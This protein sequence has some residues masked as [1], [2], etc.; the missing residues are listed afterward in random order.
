GGGNGGGNSVPNTTLPT[1]TVSS[2]S[3]QSDNKKEIVAMAEKELGA[4]I[5][6]S[7]YDKIV[8]VNESLTAS[9]SN[10]SNARNTT[11]KSAKATGL[12]ETEKK[13]NLIQIYANW[14]NADKEILNTITEKLEDETIFKTAITQGLTIFVGK[15]IANEI[16]K[17]D[18]IIDSII[19][20][21]EDIK[22]AIT[23]NKDKFTAVKYDLSKDFKFEPDMYSQEDSDILLTV[24]EKGNA[25]GIKIKSENQSIDVEFELGDLRQD[26]DGIVKGTKTKGDHTYEIF[27]GGDSMD[28]AY[29]QF[30]MMKDNFTNKNKNRE[31]NT[32]FFFGGNE[33][34][35][36]DEIK[37]T[38][39]FEGRALGSIV[40][41]EFY[42]NKENIAYMDL[43][44]TVSLTVTPGE[45]I[46]EVANFKF[47]N[48]YDITVTKEDKNYD[49][50]SSSEYTFATDKKVNNYTRE[51]F[52]KEDENGIVAMRP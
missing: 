38:F 3:V 10:Y 17:A 39:T 36:I 50:V 37:N 49:W 2:F 5:D 27:L 34:K 21:A 32:V 26:K 43:D 42:E 16:A 30:G 48:W 28:L 14:I 44:G 18:N 11:S 51:H 15:E 19:E 6:T 31:S 1:T 41:G 40:E 24:D 47:D 9:A 46:K 52:M 12:S 13:Y 8:S 7:N 29:A 45:T 20:K 35:K 23:E 25:K 22:T 4:P 33:K